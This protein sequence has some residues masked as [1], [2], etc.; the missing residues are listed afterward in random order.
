MAFLSPEPVTMYLSSTE[1][2]QLSTDEDSLDWERDTNTLQTER[3]THGYREAGLGDSEQKA[4]EP[5]PLTEIEAPGG[6]SPLS[7]V[8]VYS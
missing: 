3:K 5:A 4:A 8:K 2:S 7:P 1:M 6:N